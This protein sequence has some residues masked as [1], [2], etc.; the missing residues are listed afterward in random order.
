MNGGGG[1]YCNT[2]YHDKLLYSYKFIYLYIYFYIGV[3]FKIKLGAKACKIKM[4]EMTT[5]QQT[6]GTTPMIFYHC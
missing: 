5:P 2:K 1:G 6:M 3:D 4:G